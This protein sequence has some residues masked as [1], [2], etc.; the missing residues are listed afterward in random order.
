MEE[1]L[2]AHTGQSVERLREDTD[3]DLI[4]TAAQ[5]VEYGIADLILDSRKGSAGMNGAA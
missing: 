2:S 4:L 3:R 5:A 1:I